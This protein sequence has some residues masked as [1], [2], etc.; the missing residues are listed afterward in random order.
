MVPVRLPFAPAEYV[1]VY[2]FNSKLAVTVVFSAGI[3]KVV[4]AE[5][6]SAK[7][8]LPVVV[9]FTNLYPIAAFAVI[10]TES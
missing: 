10:A 9:Q 8:P 7:L 6:E 4:E 3:V 2:V 1:N 5:F